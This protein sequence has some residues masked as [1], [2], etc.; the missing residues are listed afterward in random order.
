MFCWS[1]VKVPFRLAVVGA[2][3]FLG[4]VFGLN[5]PV[6]AASG[7]PEIPSVFWWDNKTES[8]ITEHVN[9]RYGGSWEAYVTAWEG[10][11]QRL[12]DIQVRGSRIAIKEQG[13]I[14]SGRGL[15]LYVDVVGERLE[16]LRCLMNEAIA[17]KRQGD[18]EAGRALAEAEACVGCHGETGISE[19][20]KIPNL[21]G[22]RIE[23]LRAQLFLFRAA[24]KVVRNR[25]S[26]SND[27]PLRYD[28]AMS[29]IAGGLS[30]VGIKNLSAHYVRLPCGS[31]GTTGPIDPPRQIERCTSCHGK[32]GISERGGFPHLAGQH[33]RYL[34]RQLGLLQESVD[35]DAE[36][37]DDVDTRH[38]SMMGRQADP[39]SEEDIGALARYYA[40]LP[41]R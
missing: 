37:V 5:R 32:D 39:L 17:A 15:D 24:A 25:E 21:A 11:L 7:C 18:P 14:L 13:I 3:I 27:K 35:L 33:E 31:S 22:Q 34:R 40:N 38:H 8:S 12:K 2:L 9:E 30:D 29:L 28:R 16:V 19:D 41:C 10:R 4:L 20:G 36:V 6:S 26:V 23:Y 1:I